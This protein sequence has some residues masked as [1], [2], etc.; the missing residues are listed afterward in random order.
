[1]LNAEQLQFVESGSKRIL[2]LAGAG[3][4]KALKNGT[5]VLTPSGFVPIE[6]LKIGDLV[7]GR[8]GLPYPVTGVFPQGMKSVYRITF[9]GGIS[10]DCND[11]HLWF[12]RNYVQRRRNAPYTVGALRDMMDIPLKYV[13]PSGQRNNLYIPLCDTVQFQTKDKLPLSPYLIG[14]LIANGGFSQKHVVRVTSVCEDV[15]Q[16]LSCICAS[17]GCELSQYKNSIS[18]GIRGYGGKNYILNTIRSLGLLGKRS[19]FKYIP[20]VYKFASAD[21]RL[22]LLRGLFDGDGCNHNNIDVYATSSKQLADDITFLCES[23]GMTVTTT[24]RL[25]KYSYR[26]EKKLGLPAYRLFIKTPDG[27]PTIYTALRHMRRS[28]SSNTHAR[29]YVKSIEDLGYQAE[30][31]CISVGS[32]DSS[33]LTEHFIVTHNTH[34]TISKLTTLVNSGVNP[35]NILALTFTNAAALE[36]RKRFERSIQSETLPRFCTFHGFCYSLLCTNPDVRD[37]LGYANVPTIASEADVKYITESCIYKFGIKLPKSVLSGKTKPSIRDRYEF[38]LYQTSVYRE[39]RKNNMISFDVLCDHVCKLFVSGHESVKR[40]I[41]QYTHIFVDEFQ[42][43]DPLQWK[44]IQAFKDS[45]IAIVGD[46]KQAIYG[47]RGADSTIIK[48]IASDP[49]WETMSLDINYRSNQWICDYANKIHDVWGDTR[50]NLKLVSNSGYSIDD[51]VVEH[52][53]SLRSM[54]HTLTDCVGSSAAVLCR[55]NKEVDYVCNLLSNANIRY[56]RKKSYG[57]YDVL[58]AAVDDQY[59]LRYQLSLLPNATY[60]EYL[61]ESTVRGDSFD[62]DQFLESVDCDA[63]HTFR[64]TVKNLVSILNT[65]E[66]FGSAY[67]LVCKELGIN[68]V[69]DATPHTVYDLLQKLDRTESCM[70]CDG[71]YVGTI[72]SSKGLEYDTVHLLWSDFDT[73]DIQTDELRNLFYVGCTR[74]KTFLHI[75]KSL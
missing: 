73:Y 52:D 11:E 69:G 62:S 61:R 2:C 13:S 35:Y 6:S 68:L 43:T 28:V 60:C 3:T 45:N 53:N 64:T 47:F 24:T 29:R 55:T 72:H 67:Q 57:S 30:M 4:G 31:T 46:A 39:L 19:E 34:T 74:A 25:T 12:F 70:D 54:I 50:Y 22:E 59:R 20:D 66:S 14:Y 38:D 36:M 18:Y 5:G 26:G 27:Y 44:F 58:L 51:C 1:M 41:E 10:I 56:Y 63:L 15:I 48:A 42:D 37:A 75:W 33:F 7:Y 71:L 32:P 23:L 8:D 21:D 40:Y 17:Y 16:K 9:N 65:S 49:T